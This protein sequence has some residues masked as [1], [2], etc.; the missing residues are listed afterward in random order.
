[1]S[2]AGRRTQR[3]HR[4]EGHVGHVEREHGD[5]IGAACEE[6]RLAE[7]EKPDAGEKQ[8]PGK[9]EDDVDGDQPG[10]EDDASIEEMGHGGE[11]GEADQRDRQVQ[12]EARAVV[13]HVGCSLPSR[14]SG[15]TSRITAS[16]MR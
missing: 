10:E 16:A 14:P 8:I 1:M 7:G 13:T 4:Q 5:H 6:H 2:A 15:L 9:R 12:P 11:G 3:D